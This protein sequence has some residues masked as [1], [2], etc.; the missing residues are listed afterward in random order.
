[1]Y[2]QIFNDDQQHCIAGCS[3]RSERV[4]Q[5]LADGITKVEAAR[6]AGREIARIA[7]EKGIKKVAF[8]RAGYKYHGRVKALAEAVREAGIDF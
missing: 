7:L 4:R 5:Q 2:C 1:M 3:T 6:V 8:D